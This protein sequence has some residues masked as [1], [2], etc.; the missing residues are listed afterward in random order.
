MQPSNVP[1]RC[2]FAAFLPVPRATSR[3]GAPM[4]TDD[5]ELL[6]ARVLL[7]SGRWRRGGRAGWWND[8]TRL[9]SAGEPLGG[10]RRAWCRTQAESALPRMLVSMNPAQLI[11]HHKHDASPAWLWIADPHRVS[12]QPL[13]IRIP[14]FIL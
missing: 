1:V 4:H 7:G 12:G 11:L 13:G 5:C 9:V 2:S 3:P 10:P 6:R 8:G 14:D